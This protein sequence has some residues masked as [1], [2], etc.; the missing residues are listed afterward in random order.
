MELEEMYDSIFKHMRECIYA[1]LE[2][3]KETHREK[4]RGVKELWWKLGVQ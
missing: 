1:M 4:K 2:A 3:C